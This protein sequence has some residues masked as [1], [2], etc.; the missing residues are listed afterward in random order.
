[1]GMRTIVLSNLRLNFRRLEQAWQVATSLRILRWYAS[2]VI[3][4][5]SKYKNQDRV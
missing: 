1:M 5:R 2:D 3:L 4:A